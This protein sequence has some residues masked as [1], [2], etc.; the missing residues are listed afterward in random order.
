MTFEVISY[1][2]RLHR[3]QGYLIRRLADGALY[4]IGFRTRETA[5]WATGTLQD[6]ARWWVRD[7]NLVIFNLHKSLRESLANA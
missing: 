4:L 7:P 5:Q 3:P 1:S 6:G 2:D